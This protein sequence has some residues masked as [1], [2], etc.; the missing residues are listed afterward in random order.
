LVLKGNS[1]AARGEAIEND[2]DVAAGFTHYFELRPKH[3][4]T[5][6]VK[7]GMDGKPDAASL[8]ELVKSR[9]IVKFTLL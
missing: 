2:A 1:V 6:H 8:S 3:A 5:F 9:L 7:L 4:S